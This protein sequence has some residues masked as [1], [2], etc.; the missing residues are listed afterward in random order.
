MTPGKLTIAAIAAIGFAG[1]AVQHSIAAPVTFHFAGEVDTVDA[2]LS[3]PFNLG[4]KL[5][6]SYT[7][8]STTAPRAGSDSNTAVFDALTTFGFTLGSYSASSNSALEIQT[9]NQGG[10]ETTDRYAVV[11]R[12]ADGLTGA[13]VNGA[14]LIFFGLRVDD[15]T[16]TVFSDALILPD[17]LDLSDFDGRR[18]FMDFR[19]SDGDI[20]SVGGFLTRLGLPVPAPGMV[21]LFGL[22]ALLAG[23]LARRRA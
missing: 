8:E 1:S 10:G 3:P 5:T 7:F 12:A 2:N 16:G 15:G 23:G 21:A 18:F 13:D 19:Q 11:S 20:V 6:G 22:A 4:D 9:G 14:S 17:A